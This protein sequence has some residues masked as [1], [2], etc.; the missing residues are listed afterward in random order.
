MGK[1]REQTLTNDSLVV[2]HL[3]SLN[4]N[5]DGTDVI[6]TCSV[7]EIKIGPTRINNIVTVLNS[8]KENEII[9]IINKEDSLNDVYGRY[10]GLG[11]KQLEQVDNSL[12]EYYTLLLKGL[13][14]NSIKDTKFHDINLF[15]KICLKLNK[16]NLTSKSFISLFVETT[17][18]KGFLN[19]FNYIDFNEIA[20]CDLQDY[21]IVHKFSDNYKMI[22]I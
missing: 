11:K 6:N 5:I 12:M 3:K 4:K 14:I 13:K 2:E 8:T 10:R 16:D 9:S 15:L 22:A 7:L 21:V 20:L 18:K 1:T 19:D 17:N